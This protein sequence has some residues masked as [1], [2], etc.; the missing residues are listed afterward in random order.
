MHSRAS[1]LHAVVLAAVSLVALTGC[2]TAAPADCLIQRPFLQGYTIKFTLTSTPAAGCEDVLP[3]IYADNWRFDGFA[4]HQIWVKSDNMPFPDEGGP[5]SPVL[6]NGTFSTTPDADS[7]CT[8]PEITPMTSDEDPLGLGL[9]HFVYEARNLRF[10]DGARYQGS[11]F[12]G[13]VDITFGTCTGTY[14]MQGLSPSPIA[15]I[16][17]CEDDAICDPFGDP[18]AGILASGLNPDYAI[19]CV[20]EQW[21]T[22][23]LTGDLDLGICF[24]TKPFPGL[25]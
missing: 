15:F 20:K 22:D 8:I 13:E 24:F 3:P 18:A 21:V 19:A 14:S 23:F 10:L 16:G 11:T 9:D 4:D 5:T 12:E 6:G 1:G 2:P 17:A 25:K 7:I